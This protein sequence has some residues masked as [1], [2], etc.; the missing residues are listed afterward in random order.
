[1][2][3]I[4]KNRGFVIDSLL[5]GLIITLVCV[6][7]SSSNYDESIFCFLTGIILLFSK[8]LKEKSRMYSLAFWIASNIFKPRTKIN[9]LIW[10]VFFILFA[11]IALFSQPVSMS[12]TNFLRDI[13]GSAEFWI[14]I[15]LVVLFNL[16]VG[17][18]TAYQ[19]RK[20]S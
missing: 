12:K 9:H 3:K 13:E 5:V 18:Y 1:M 15:G 8:I 16:L 6:D 20:N 4:I 10:G 7:G 11:V 14:G 2:N 17:L 19:K